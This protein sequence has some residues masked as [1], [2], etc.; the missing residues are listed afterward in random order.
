MLVRHGLLAKEYALVTLHRPSNVDRKENLIHIIDF[1]GGL[2]GD[3]KILFPVHPRTSKNIQAFGLAETAGKIDILEPLRY[4][5]FIVLLKNAKF[6][7]TDSGGIQ[8][9]TTYLDVPCL[10]LRNN[11]E[12]PVT[13]TQGT[14]ELVGMDNIRD[15][16]KLILEGRWKRTRIPEFW[17]GG[18]SGRICSVLN[19]KWGAGAA[20]ISNVCQ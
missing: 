3:L 8:E 7:L 19:D 5:E 15:K 18:V 14:N 12:R 20:S 1:L 6:V 2:S 17:D 9:E 10:T 16:V 13:L 11:T 4:K